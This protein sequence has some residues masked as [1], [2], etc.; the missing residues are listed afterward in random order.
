MDKK[1][2]E[3]LDKGYILCRC[4]IEVA[5]TPKA[6]IEKTIKLVVETIKNQEDIILKSGDVFET[7]EVDMK[8]LKHK[9]KLYSTYTEIE[10]LFKNTQTLLGFCFDYMPS[11]VELLD[12]KDLVFDTNGFAGLINDLIAKLHTVDMLLKNL[13]AENQILN[14]N[15]S[16]LLR[17]LIILSLSSKPKR[18]NMV[19]KDT[20]IPEKQLKPFMDVMV[21]NKKVK[22]EKGV[23]SLIK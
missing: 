9:G 3:K 21:Q 6:H 1:L 12:P 14:Q 17:N 4:I 5:G 13:K 22:V 19:S 10:L 18:I 20:G 23:Y 7:K 2:Q 8:D 15:A 11:S 16:D